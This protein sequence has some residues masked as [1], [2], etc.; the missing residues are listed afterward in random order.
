MD[1]EPG[2]LKT[3][4][5][6][7]LD[8]NYRVLTAA[9]ADTALKLLATNPVQVILSDQRMPGMSGIEFLSRVKDLYPDTVRMVL[10]GYADPETV[11]EAVNEGALYK[12]LAK[13]WRDD[14]LL[15]HISDAFLY[16]EMIIK[17]RQQR[18]V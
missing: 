16:Y 14:L 11:L 1:D 15:K 6:L 13:P 3:L 2:I 4:Q 7:T 17:P 10:S 8:E 12:F 18:R 5:R 9:D